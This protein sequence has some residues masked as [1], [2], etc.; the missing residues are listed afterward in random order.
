MAK[1]NLDSGFLILYDWLPAFRSLN[2]DELKKLLFALIEHQRE[3]T[4][5]PD[6]DDPITSIFAQMIAPTIKRRLDGLAS[7]TRSAKPEAEKCAKSKSQKSRSQKIS[8]FDTADNTTKNQLPVG[9][10]DTMP[11]GT[12]KGMSKDTAKSISKD[13]VEG[14]VEGSSH[15]RKEDIR[16]EKLSGAEIRKAERS[17]ADRAPIVFDASMSAVDFSRSILASLSKSPPQKNET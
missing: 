17:E 12:V 2:G 5:L 9:V 14:T 7:A 11:E 10:S 4:P 15:P 3:G 8:E 13:T 16:K 1:A 6:F